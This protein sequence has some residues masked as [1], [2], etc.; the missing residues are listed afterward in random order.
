[1]KYKKTIQ[2]IFSSRSTIERI[3]KNFKILLLSYFLCQFMNKKYN[4]QNNL[5]NTH[6]AKSTINIVITH[7]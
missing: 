2:L 7:C 4:K 5:F 6:V 1:M 3:K